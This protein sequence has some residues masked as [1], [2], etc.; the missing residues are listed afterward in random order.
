MTGVI[1]PYDQLRTESLNGVIEESVARDG[2]DYGEVEISLGTK[3]WV[4]FCAI[5]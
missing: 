4:V 2:T 3:I 1:V 5:D